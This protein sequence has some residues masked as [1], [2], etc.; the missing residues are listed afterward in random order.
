VVYNPQWKPVV[1]AVPF[2][3]CLATLNVALF[4]I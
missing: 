2:A 3:D 1:A 4:A